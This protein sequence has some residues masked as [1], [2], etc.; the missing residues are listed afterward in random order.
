M[1]YSRVGDRSMSG[2]TGCSKLDM[3][4]LLL[5]GAGIIVL[6]S[7]IYDKIVPFAPAATSV[8]ALS[9]GLMRSSKNIL[10]NIIVLIVSLSWGVSILYPEYAFYAMILVYAASV[11]AA[12]DSGPEG[13]IAVF[14]TSMI[15]MLV[16]F[17][18]SPEAIIVSSI[19]YIALAG[20]IA[21]LVSNSIHP[22][23]IVV[24][25]PIVVMLGSNAGLAASTIAF[26]TVIAVTGTTKIVGCPFHIDSGLL[27]VGTIIGI[28]GVLLMMVESFSGDLLLSIG[29]WTLGFLFQLAGILV[30]LLPPQKTSFSEN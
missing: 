21:S 10:K 30:P 12:V 29:L 25:A 2:G 23:I 9:I 20:L 4:C 17:E 15:P 26:M 5:S 28:L 8:V 14:S 11:I 27:F 1:A 7:I 16:G 6:M 18:W 22:L 24:A 13:G 3:G 19:I